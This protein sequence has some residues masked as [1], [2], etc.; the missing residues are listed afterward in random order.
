MHIGGYLYTY[1]T[2]HVYTSLRQYPGGLADDSQ[3]GEACD[4]TDEEG[5]HMKSY[6][7]D[8]Q[9]VKGLE[10]MCLPSLEVYVIIQLKCL[11]GLHII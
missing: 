1:R 10:F 9:A 6:M 3:E 4:S 5:L 7:Y 8:Q 2:G 11:P